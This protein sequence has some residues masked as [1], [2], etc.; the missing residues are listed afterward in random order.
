M[1]GTF[2]I[3]CPSD[4]SLS[5]LAN[6]MNT[7]TS[8]AINTLEPNNYNMLKRIHLQWFLNLQI[9]ELRNNHKLD[10]KN[11]TQIKGTAVTVAMLR[12]MNGPIKTPI[13][14]LFVHK[15]LLT[16]ERYSNC[17]ALGPS[18]WWRRLFLKHMSQ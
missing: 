3:R 7:K 16:S 12:R 14:R 11:R 4:G 10:K 8:T 2:Q 6:N 9:K 13:I 18:S 1:L 17:P 15:I 5:R